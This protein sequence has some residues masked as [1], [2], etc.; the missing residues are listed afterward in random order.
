MR[1][2][3]F[4]SSEIHKL[5]KTGKS[6]DAVF[7]APGLTYIQEKRYEQRLGR[8]L[9]TQTNAKPTSWGNLMELY[10]WELKMGISD[11]RFENKTRYSHE[12]VESWTGCPDMVGDDRV[13]DIKCPFTL[14]AFCEL[15]DCDSGEKLKENKPEYYWQLVSNAILTGKDSAELIVFVP[16]KSELNDI[17]TFVDT[18]DVLFRN[19]LDQNK[20][21]WMNWAGDEDLP[22]IL[23][24]GHYSNL[25]T[26]SFDIPQAD[27][28]LLTDRVK[29]AVELL[30]Q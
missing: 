8:S 15:I 19:G 3:N 27:K 5:I 13:A 26:M 18:S 11:Y 22:Y 6:K 21:G 7:S 29:Q 9:T 28:D 14:K 16:Y 4:S 1:A 30:N 23:D 20:F 17:R 2:G 24:E 10:V 25:N 12:S